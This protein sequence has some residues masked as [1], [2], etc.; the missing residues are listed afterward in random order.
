M[1]SIAPLMTQ[2]ANL[3][4]LHIAKYDDEPRFVICNQATAQ[5]LGNEAHV[6][7]ELEHSSTKATIAGLD[8]V[9][10]PQDTRREI[11]MEVA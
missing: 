6:L 7:K 8:L 11:V 4:R 1:S 5:Q 2:L 3:K 10:Y 9:M